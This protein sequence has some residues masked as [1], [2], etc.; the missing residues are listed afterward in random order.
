M[1]LSALITA[2]VFL[3]LEPALT[4]SATRSVSSDQPGGGRAAAV[5]MMGSFAVVAGMSSDV[6]ELAHKRSR[7][8]AADWRW[9]P[10]AAARDSA[11]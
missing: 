5:L 3:G 10:S 9:R 6:Y 8:A 4:V 7:I 2:V 1:G 11:H